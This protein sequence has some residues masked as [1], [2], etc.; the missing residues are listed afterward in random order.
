[1]AYTVEFKREKEPTGFP[2]NATCSFHLPANFPSTFR[3][4]AEAQALAG[5]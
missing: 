5:A 1:M 3:K 2:G 4:I